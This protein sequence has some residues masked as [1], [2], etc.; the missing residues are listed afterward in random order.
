MFINYHLYNSNSECI[1]LKIIVAFFV[2]FIGIM[3]GLEIPVI[4]RIN[5]DY[6]EELSTN[7]GN[8]LS[9]DYLGSL[10]GALVY[11]YILIRYV[12]ITEAAFLTA[13]INFILAFA[14]FNAL[15]DHHQLLRSLPPFLHQTAT[16]ISTIARESTAEHL[17]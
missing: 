7:L 12:P 11:V 2:S 9:A 10:A 3:I 17:G 16:I 4:I 5:N 8:I 6:T 14:T 1:F 13:G 15:V